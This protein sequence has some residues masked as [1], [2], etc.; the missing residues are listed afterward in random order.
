MSEAVV[1]FSKS[2]AVGFMT[3]DRPPVNSYE[4]G[5]MRD[6]DAAIETAVW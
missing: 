4:I 1:K 5:F 3:L 2:G 6:L